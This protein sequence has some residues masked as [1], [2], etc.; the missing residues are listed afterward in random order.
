MVRTKKGIEKRSSSGSKRHLKIL[1]WTIIVFIVLAGGYIMWQYSVPAKELPPQ[2]RV[3]DKGAIK[4]ELFGGCG[5]G[6]EVMRIAGY[7]R[8]IGV[9]VV[10]IKQESGYIYPS[11]LI[12]DRCGNSIIADSLAGLIGIPKNRVVLQ[13]YDLMVDATIV[14]GLDYPTI[15]NKLSRKEI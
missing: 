6:S 2:H 3:P 15:V 13:R 1:D 9:D 5:R 14:V 7:L 12:V 11:S 4:I 10:D 8:E